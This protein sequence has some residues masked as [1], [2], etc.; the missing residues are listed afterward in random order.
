[1]DLVK[2]GGSWGLKFV[3]IIGGV[4]GAITGAGSAMGR[5]GEEGFNVK[6]VFQGL[7]DVVGGALMGFGWVGAAISAVLMGL[8][9]LIDW[10][11]PFRKKEEE[12]GKT[13]SPTAEA[14][15]AAA[16][17]TLNQYQFRTKGG[18][19]TIMSP[20]GT[21]PLGGNFGLHGGLSATAAAARGGGGGSGADKSSI[22]QKLLAAYSSSGLVGVIPNDGAKFGIKKGTAEEWTRFAM[23]VCD[24]ESGFD[25]QTQNLADK[26]GSFGIFQYAHGQVPGGDAFNID[27]SI[28]AFV[29]DSVTS[30]GDLEGGL[31]GKRFSTI[32]LHPE[33]TISRLGGSANVATKGTGQGDG[34]GVGVVQRGGQEGGGPVSGG[35]VGQEGGVATS[36]AIANTST[37]VSSYANPNQ[38]PFPASMQAVGNTAPAAFIAHHTGGRGTVQS[39]LDTLNQRHLGV[40][41]IMD[42][43]GNIFQTGQAG[44][45]NILPGSKFFKGGDP[46]SGLSNKN[47]IGMEI[48]AKDDSDVTDAQRASFAKFIA[49]RYPNTPVLGHGEVNP[50]HKEADEG[51]STSR[52][53]LALRARLNTTISAVQAR[54]PS[55]AVSTSLLERHL[56]SLNRGDLQPVDGTSRDMLTEIKSSGRATRDY[57]QHQM[58]KDF[59]GHSLL[60]D[61]TDELLRVV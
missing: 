5:F 15:S 59:L 12:K 61:S 8:N 7:F 25:P 46:R 22:R 47:I 1:M 24:A 37:D 13:V 3:P 42:R 41:Y 34:G 23:A 51:R 49:A 26:G 43:E 33:R 60:P 14:Q 40:E 16:A 58:K 48:I 52:A 54:P 27:A 6:S 32:G 29:R 31:L 53:A 17:G 50:G 21:N 30:Q 9:S 35:V 20:G 56:R 57:Y 18:N 44:A 55:A 11:W 39:V 45:S 28:A 36:T 2:F 19:Q 38:T 4:I 10:L